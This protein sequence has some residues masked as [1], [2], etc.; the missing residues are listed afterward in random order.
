M[1]RVT[2][3]PNHEAPDKRYADEVGQY[4]NRMG[5]EGWRFHSTIAGRGVRMMVFER[6]SGH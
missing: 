3:W 6:A 5:S 2:G 4:L 1:Y